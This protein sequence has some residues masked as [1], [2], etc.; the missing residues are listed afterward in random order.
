MP[1]AREERHALLCA[2][3]SVTWRAGATDHPSRRSLYNT[4]LGR[5]L[6]EKDGATQQMD[7]DFVMLYISFAAMCLD[8]TC[9]AWVVLSEEG[10]ALKVQ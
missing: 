7:H 6:R 2:F 1:A 10:S 4:K 3:W 5:V 8:T 9:T